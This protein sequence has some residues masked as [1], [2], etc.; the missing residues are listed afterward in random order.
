MGLNAHPVSSAACA[1]VTVSSSISSAVS[2]SSSRLGKLA[3]GASAFRV[4]GAIRMTAV[5]GALA[6]VRDGDFG[7]AS[8]TRATRA[9]SSY[10]A[11]AMV[12]HGWGL[13][14]GLCRACI[15]D[16]V[17]RASKAP[18][19]ERTPDG[20]RV[21]GFALACEPKWGPGRAVGDAT[22]HGASQCLLP[23]LV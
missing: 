22:C 19:C 23:V 12:K 3:V 11:S 7:S 18:P 4:G 15:R 6:I 21:D 9:R 1:T 10:W 20:L 8:Q 5:A 2:S 17:E 13:L 14:A 16:N